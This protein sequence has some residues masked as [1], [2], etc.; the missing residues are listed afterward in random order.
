MLCLVVALAAEARPLL[1][2]HRHLRVL[3]QQFHALHAEPPGLAEPTARWQFTTTQQYQL[4]GLL[5][6]WQALAPA[7]PAVNNDLLALQRR[8]EVLRYLQRQLAA[9][10]FT[11]IC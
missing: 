3:S 1:A 8:D 11:L 6:R 5:A 7:T 9:M 4:R 2:S 10:V